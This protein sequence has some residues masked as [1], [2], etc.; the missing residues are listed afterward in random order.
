[1]E[2]K[3]RDVFQIV[4]DRIIVQLE[5]GVIP[6]K[7]N[8]IANDLA[9]P[10]NLSTRKHYRGINVLLLSSLG[11]E[12]NFFLTVNQLMEFG[13]KVKEGEKGCPVVYWKTFEEEEG[14]PRRKPV[15]RYYTVYNIAQCDGVDEKDIPELPEVFD[16]II[17]CEEIVAGMPQS[18][19]IT[20]SGNSAFYSPSLDYVNM[21][22]R[23]CFTE[24]EEYYTTLF[25]EL[26]HSTG[27]PK[28]IARKELTETSQS[29]ESYSAE[30]LT[31]EIGA[32][33]LN[34]HSGI[35]RKPFENNVAYIGGWLKRLKNDN[36]FIVYASTQAQKAVDY[37]LN[38]PAEA[39][40]KS[41][42]QANNGKE[43]TP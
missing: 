37:I 9:L 13:G 8:W 31:A 41:N 12:R 3:K 1:M 29:R 22:P 10:M 15:L 25:H 32:C 28:R 38:L 5:K 35:D 40:V 23:E 43:E 19:S 6:W 14:K 30:E 21:P 36:R 26:V 16:P 20:H 17:A 18:P 42:V 4:T 34:A 33:F 11:Y 7:Q 39:P 2:T 27:H 24:A